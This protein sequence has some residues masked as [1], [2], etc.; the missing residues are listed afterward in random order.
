[1][2]I[3]FR[4]EH[5][6]QLLGISRSRA[7]ATV[8]CPQCGR[9]LK[10]P[11]AVG[12]TAA[13]NAASEGADDSGLQDADLMSALNELTMLG[14]ADDDWESPPLRT[15]PAS[16]NPATPNSP[17]HTDTARAFDDSGI[18]IQGK[19]VPEVRAGRSGDLVQRQVV[20][21][22]VANQAMEKPT[23]S[24]FES[25]MTSA[26]AL[27]DLAS[28]AD[29]SSTLPNSSAPAQIATDLLSEMR[30]VSHPSSWLATSIAAALLV[31]I[32]G[33]AGWWLAKSESLERWL[34]TEIRIGQDLDEEQDLRQ[35]KAEPYLPA[36]IR[37]DPSEWVITVTGQ[38]QYMDESGQS[39]PDGGAAVYLLPSSRQGNLKVHALSFRREAS[40]A[41]RR[42]SEAALHALG[43]LRVEADDKGQFRIGTQAADDEYQLVVVSR[44]RE[45]PANML[46]ESDIT[47]ALMPWFDSTVHVLGKRDAVIKLLV[48]SV[49]DLIITVGSDDA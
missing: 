25:P 11:G 13:K 5:C 18:V 40:N 2:P 12:D 27:Q 22:E 43:G 39:L 32:S 29:S 4:C 15:N 28:W 30:Q 9:S 10:V 44:H 38:V 35:A 47:N 49:E 1:M 7:A 23:E 45:R 36:A 3:K 6:Q 33:A 19:D 42:F 34:G 21:A 17:R 24:S 46:P 31:L 14:Q 48:E 16:T 26:E 8:D 20:A 37:F 41:D